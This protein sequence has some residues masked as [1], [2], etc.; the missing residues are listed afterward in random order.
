[1]KT[2]IF[3]LAKK[4]WKKYPEWIVGVGGASIVAPL[5]Y[6]SYKKQ[7]RFGKLAK[8]HKLDPGQDLKS[9]AE[10]RRFTKLHKEFY[11]L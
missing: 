1:M 8:K 6:S 10:L 2:K 9:K 4:A 3:K 5:G 11:N 7:K